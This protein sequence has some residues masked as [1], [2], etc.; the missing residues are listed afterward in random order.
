MSFL[1]SNFFIS[2]S[3]FNE[4]TKSNEE[5]PYWKPLLVIDLFVYCIVLPSITLFWTGT[6]FLALIKTKPGNKPL[7]VLYS[8]FLWVLALD[9]LVTTI[10][11][12]FITPDMLQYCMCN[13]IAAI[14]S[15]I[16]GVFVTAYSAVIIS[17]QSFLQLQIVRGKKQWNSYYRIIPCVGISFLIAIVW[18]VIVLLQELFLPSTLNPCQNLCEENSTNM[19]EAG[20]IIIGVYSISTFLPAVAITITT[21]I[22][23]VVLFQKMSIQQKNQEYKNL[24]KKLLLMPIL[25]VII[26][27]G[28]GL[29]GYLISM[30][31]SKLLLLIGVVD[32]IGNWAYASNELI[33]SVTG[34][35]Q[36]ISYSITLLIASINL[37]KTWRNLFRQKLNRVQQVNID[38]EITE[39]HTQLEFCVIE[40]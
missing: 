37:R 6:V 36:G 22:W 32:H 4:S 19:S 2:S 3:V 21:S 18:S 15:I 30:A 35:Y 7:I 33:Y 10:V 8:S 5:F 34:Y 11:T 29:L 23:S 40:L 39:S 24:N 27:I 12:I 28:N 14:F 16:K 31:F 13:N 38:T 26:L 17:C 1:N 25:M 20:S 9:K